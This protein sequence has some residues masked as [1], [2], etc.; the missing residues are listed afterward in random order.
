MA[1]SIYYSN[2]IEKLFIP[3]SFGLTFPVKNASQQQQTGE[4]KRSSE[5]K[6]LL[7]EN[8]W[9]TSFQKSPSNIRNGKQ[10]RTTSFSVP[11]LLFHATLGYGI[12]YVMPPTK[13]TILGT[14][15]TILFLSL[16]LFAHSFLSNFLLKNTLK[17]EKYSRQFE[18]RE[19]RKT[20]VFFR[21][22]FLECMNRIRYRLCTTL[23]CKMQ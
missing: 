12:F 13:D 3:R 17:K 5:D 8:P 14:I 15:S 23:S 1:S 11:S 20:V 22:S 7:E 18:L 2:R 19:L 6:K 9:Q 4:I 16:L 21:P 10:K